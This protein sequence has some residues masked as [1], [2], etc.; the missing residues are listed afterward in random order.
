ML[1]DGTISDILVNTFDSVYVERRGVLEKTSVTFKDNAHLLQ[2]IDKIV[3][4]RGSSHRRVFTDGGCAV[5]KDGSRV[6]VIVPP[7]AVDGPILSIRRFGR[8]PLKAEDLD[9]HRH[10]DARRC[11]SCW[12]RP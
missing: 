8:S 9:P 7:L 1:E 2:I 11:L 6:N 4:R 5:G 3:S 12:A 10:G